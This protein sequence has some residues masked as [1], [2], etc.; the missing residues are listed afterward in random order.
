MAGASA[1]KQ[2]LYINRDRDEHRRRLIC[3]ELGRIG[4]TATRLPAVDRLAVP[5]DLAGYFAH[6]A[7]KRAPLI[8]PGAIG[9]YAS[10]LRAYKQIIAERA[11][12]TLVL[13]DDAILDDDLVE[14]I[15][16]TLA[17]LPADWDMVHLGQSPRYAVKPLAALPNRRT[18]VRYSRIPS[19]TVGYLISLAG[20]RKML[21]P[22]LQ[23]FW[24]IDLDTRRPWVFGLDV[25][26]VVAPPIWPNKQLPSTITTANRIKS[27][28]RRGLPRPTAYSWTNTPLHTPRGLVFNVGKL[29]P[30]WWLRCFAI[31][32]AVKLR[33]A[34]VPLARHLATPA[35]A[36]A[37]HR[38]G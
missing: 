16:Q 13:E 5:P 31:N 17:A 7:Q 14:V 3:A 35:R 26:G 10:H 34:L 38:Q 12:A 1:L 19:G 6:V 11:A 36:H 21:D 18:L 32:C 8:P 33:A 9:C 22:A 30:L 37:N 27:T 29:G 15:R 24:A 28:A 23:R 2:I 25:Y 20:A 4:L